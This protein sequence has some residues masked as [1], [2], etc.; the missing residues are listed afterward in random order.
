MRKLYFESTKHPLKLCLV[1]HLALWPPDHVTIFKTSWLLIRSERNDEVKGVWRRGELRNKDKWHNEEYREQKGLN[2][3]VFGLM[4][5]KWQA[6]GHQCENLMGLASEVGLAAK[7]KS[8]WSWLL[9][10]MKRCARWALTDSGKESGAISG[11]DKEIKERASTAPFIQRWQR[12]STP[13]DD[14]YL[15][16]TVMMISFMDQ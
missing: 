1:Q 14:V 13:P 4:W 11:A 16:S 9:W 12:S 3:R 7:M 10:W 5:A 6:L 8:L 2:E 15:Q